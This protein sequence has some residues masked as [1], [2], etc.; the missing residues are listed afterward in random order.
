MML[1][2]QDYHSG[3]SLWASAPSLQ[4][5]QQAQRQVPSKPSEVNALMQRVTPEDLSANKQA[6]V[7][8]ILALWLT[9]AKAQQA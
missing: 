3:T 4:A 1:H 8:Q 5:V 9:E 2:H 6:V 7:R